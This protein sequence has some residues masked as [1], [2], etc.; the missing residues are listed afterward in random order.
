MAKRYDYE[1][2]Y[3]G[4]IT[5]SVFTKKQLKQMINGK[6]LEGFRTTA[7]MKVEE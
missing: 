1:E 6:I 5:H 3:E 4:E 2:K 7:R